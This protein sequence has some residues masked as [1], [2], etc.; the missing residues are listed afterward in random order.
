MAITAFP[1]L[2]A[3]RAILDLGQPLY[4]LKVNVIWLLEGTARSS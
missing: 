2:N 3:V 1:Q 4:N